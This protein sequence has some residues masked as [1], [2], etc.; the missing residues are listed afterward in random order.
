MTTLRALLIERIREPTPR[1]VFQGWLRPPLHP[2]MDRNSW[3][4]KRSRA[5]RF[6]SGPRSKIPRVCGLP[7]YPR[8]LLDRAMSKRQ[9]RRKMTERLLLQIVKVW[10]K[11]SKRAACGEVNTGVKSVMSK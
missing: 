6:P 7:R 5:K 4:P 1:G 3:R 9:L 10:R 11:G 2:S 8:Y